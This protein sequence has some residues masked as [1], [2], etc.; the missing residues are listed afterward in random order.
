M[1]FRCPAASNRER[2]LILRLLAAVLFLLAAAASLHAGGTRDTILSR[3]DELIDNKQYDEAIQALTEYVKTNPGKFD[4]AQKRLQR[5]VRLREQYNTIADELLEIL[6]ENPDDNDKILELINRLTAI[7][8]VSNPSTR[9]FL[10]QILDL[11]T[12]NRN[13]NR[14]EEILEQGRI[15]LAQRDYPGALEC[16]ASGLE[17]YQSEYF[18]SGFG[19]E[20]EEAASRGLEDISRGIGEFAALMEP[21]SQAARTVENRGRDAVPSEIRQ[22][23][24]ALI[25]YMEDFSLIMNSFFGAGLAYENQLAL[26]QSQDESL[27]DRSF[28]SFAVRLIRGP[29]G[30]DEG[31]VG[32]LN[33]Y[34]QERI[35][36]VEGAIAALAEDAYTRAHALSAA[37]D[38][39]GAAPFLDTAEE[40]LGMAMDF[41]N[42][43]LVLFQASGVPV[44]MVFDE[45]V[46][47]DKAGDYLAYQ[48]MNRA[49]GFIREAG[50][51]GRQNQALGDNFP[52]FS[53]WQEGLLD[54]SAAVSAEDADRASLKAM[55]AGV[56]ALMAEIAADTRTVQG[57]PDPA[58]EGAPPALYL[59]QARDIASALET[60][61][62]TREYQAIVRRY[63]ISTEEL[64]HEVSA[65]EDEFARGNSL[66]EGIRTEENGESAIA[67]YPAEGLEALTQMSQRAAVNLAGCRELLNLFAS[68]PQGI[69]G[70][71][72]VGTLYSYARSLAG[73][74]E[75]LL[76]RTGTVSAAARIQIARAD[77]LRLEGDRLFQES[78]AAL[79]RNN[80]D[81][82]RDRLQRATERYH[83]SLVIQESASLRSSWDTRLVN[84]GAEIVRAENEIVVR[85][86]RDMV[87]RARNSYYAGNMEQAE[88]LLVRAQNRWHDTNVTEQPEVV[89]WLNLVRG[90][91]SLQSGRTI[92]ATAPLYAEMSQL[93]SD[94]RRNYDEGVRLLNAGQRPQGLNR[95]NEALQL[96]QEVRLMFPMNHDARM[97]ELRIEQQTDSAAFNAAFRQRLNE[98]VAG[99]RQKSV[100]SFA[101]LQDLAEI[102]PRYSGIGAILTQAEIDMGYRP[103]PPDPRD[104]SRSA[105]LARQAQVI[106][107]ARDSTQYEVARTQLDEALRL[108]PNNTQAQTLLDRVQILMTGTGT[109]VLSSRAQDLYTVAVQMYQQGNY[110][111]ANAIVQQLL[112]D[113][114]N[115]KSTLILEL[116]RRLDAVLL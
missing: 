51:I 108:N 94:A 91:M 66:V 14:L 15:L 56:D 54:A 17:I 92:P 84:L 10:D 61:I 89:Y 36:P 29:A 32:T 73:S 100:E 111:S 46:V 12:F 115:Q 50:I 112:Q 28:L 26:L 104:L 77:A 21:F 85:D 106:V 86:V 27:G 60:V 53:S 62:R 109:I 87:T 63:T 42:H 25:P 55:G 58:P 70:S 2:G 13:R 1:S 82:A 99:T 18:S 48:S 57:Y 98:A 45:P 65:R 23:Y 110:L 71:G 79:G 116:K 4:D 24:N 102:N 19:E 5:I 3:A 95:F 33:R 35:V 31:I 6:V 101:E 49:V 16:Y 34:W 88:D 11:A 93:L 75:N 107:G 67:H 59:D 113:P 80:F 81:V 114:G 97:L 9:R 43:Y 64:S 30:Q 83:D 90:A 74:L 47:E 22:A 37:A 68:E 103:P 38:Y 8:L 76:A 40:Y 20:A 69:S 52:A 39:A 44:T 105:E 78:Q 96:A 41:V 7:E 72:E